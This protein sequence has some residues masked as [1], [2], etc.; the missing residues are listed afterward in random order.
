MYKCEPVLSMRSRNG[1]R[2]LIF[3]S[4][5]QGYNTKITFPVDSSIDADRQYIRS[6]EITESDPDSSESEYFYS[7][8]RKLK[9]DGSWNGWN[10]R[11]TNKRWSPD[12]KTIQLQVLDESPF[13]HGRPAWPHDEYILGVYDFKATTSRDNDTNTNSP[14]VNPDSETIENPEDL[15]KYYEWK[16]LQPRP[17]PTAFIGPGFYDVGSSSNYY[18]TGT[19]SQSSSPSYYRYH[20]PTHQAITDGSGNVQSTSQNNQE[21]VPGT[22]SESSQSTRHFNPYASGSYD[23]YKRK[24]VRLQIHPGLIAAPLAGL[25]AFGAASALT[26]KPLLVELGYVRNKPEFGGQGGSWGWPATGGGGGYRPY[27][28][29]YPP[30]N[31]PIHGVGFGGGPP[32]GGGIGPIG[33]GIGPVG[34]GVGHAHATGGGGPIYPIL[35]PT[36]GGGGRPGG[37]SSWWN[38]FAGLTPRL[39]I[40]R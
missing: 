34:G 12:E 29:F 7:P 11:D 22:P 10:Y 16:R 28:P 39:V 19:A 13:H 26:S 14:Q 5:L 21:S 30:P 20:L 15:Q 24:R 6:L 37:G 18:G 17:S 32:L 40:E 25:A 3:I 4:I 36:R 9:D 8:N 23:L 33:G 2:A 27:P 1:L 31:P 38:P 35:N